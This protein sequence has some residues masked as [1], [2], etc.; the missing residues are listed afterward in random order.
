MKASETEMNTLFYEFEVSGAKCVG[1]VS[2]IDEALKENAE[3]YFKECS[4]DLL[5]KKL[6]IKAYSHIPAESI[7]KFVVATLSEKGFTASLISAKPALTPVESGFGRFFRKILRAHWIWGSIGI[8]G[9]II[10]LALSMLGITLPLAAMIAIGVFSTILTLLMGA[11]SYWDAAKKLFKTRALTMDTLFALSTLTVLVVSAIAFF[12]PWLPMMFEAGLLIFGF[13]HLGVAIEESI[14][15]STGVAVNFKDRIPK[16]VRVLIESSVVE[17]PLAAV[18]AGDLILLKAGEYIPVDGTSEEQE[19]LIDDSIETGAYVPRLVSL[20]ENLLAGMRLAANAP[21]LYLRATSTANDSNVAKMDE[22]VAHALATKAPLETTATAVLQYFI[23]AVLLL[24][25]VS[26]AIVSVFF[27]VALA[28]KCAVAVLVSACPCTIGFIIPLSIR[29]GVR[30]AAEHGVEFKSALA[31]QESANIDCVVFDLNGTLT[32]GMPSVQSFTILKNCSLSREDLLALCSELEKDS[33]HPFGQAIHEFSEKEKSAAMPEMTIDKTH[34][35]GVMGMF[36]KTEYI[37]GDK[38]LMKDCEIDTEELEEMIKPECGDHIV[39][40]AQGKQLVGYFRLNDDLRHDAVETIAW[41][42]DKLKKEV[43]IASGAARATVS[44]FAARLNIPEDNIV[45]DCK[46]SSNSP[47]NSKV[48]LIKQ[49]QSQKKRVCVVGDGAND[50]L[51]IS[52]A[53]ASFAVHSK[54]VDT[55]VIDKAGAD[56]KNGSLKGIVSG[57]VISDKTVGNI[58]QNLIFSLLYNLFTM[59]LASGLLLA[60]GISLHPAIGVALMV[61]QSSLLLWNAYRFKQEKLQHLQ[62]THASYPSSYA[63]LQKMLPTN[64]KDF[65]QETEPSMQPSLWSP[66]AEPQSEEIS[67]VRMEAKAYM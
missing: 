35:S 64:E 31:L 65:T 44:R 15:A 9:G 41:I 67:D 24:A 16:T 54:H 51:F 34:H 61:L 17:K 1:C 10:L 48:A 3:Q 18:K 22:G 11:E 66:V 56:I 52:S 19:S 4:F 29:F 62:N 14:K 36:A 58:K 25:V 37:L 45:A 38:N 53:D 26:A 23:P 20:Q 55:N 8:S 40:L 60:V 27:P 6:T 12:V 47:E 13:R 2:K 50:A 63:Q 28:I 57:L 39:Y 7:E 33:S 43:F 42:K 32:K 30:K 59:V 5:T 21:D 46:T 49:L